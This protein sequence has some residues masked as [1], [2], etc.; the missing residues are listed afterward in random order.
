M[1]FNISKLLFIS[2][3]LLGIS[4]IVLSQPSA[5]ITGVGHGRPGYS[6]GFTVEVVRG[7]LSGPVR[8][9]LNLPKD[10]KAKSYGFDKR[11]SIQEQAGETR[12]LWLSM[13]V[14]DTVRYSFDVRIPESQ[15]LQSVSIDGV[16]EYFGDD[17][18]KKTIPISSHQIKMMRY[19]SRYQ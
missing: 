6:A 5:K 8:V 9:K 12:I 4:E 1:Y 7:N 17:G 16:L 3:F 13:P 19:Y 11:A 14:I 18:K 15:P 2:F 10:W